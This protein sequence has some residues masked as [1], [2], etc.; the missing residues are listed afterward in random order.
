MIGPSM[1]GIK[2]A[3]AQARKD[4]AKQTEEVLKW[5]WPKIRTAIGP[6][7]PT[8]EEYRSGGMYLGGY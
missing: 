2:D 8:E 6:H 4:A 1:V 3:F 7:V 5:A